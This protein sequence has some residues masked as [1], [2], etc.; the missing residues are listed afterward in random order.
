MKV[1]FTIKIQKESN[2]CHSG[3]DHNRQE[4]K[5]H[6][7]SRVQQKTCSFFFFD[8]K[9]TV[10]HEFLPPNTTVNSDF[11]CDLLRCW[12]KMSAEKDWKFGA[13]TTGSITTMCP[14]KRPWKPQSLLTNNNMVIV[15]HPPY[16]LDLAPVIWLCSPKWIRNWSDDIL[17]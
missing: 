13:T 12:R 7:R 10:H 6:G 1:T 2:N 14:P 11:F 3:R 5:R 16:S 4:Q 8:V 17:K 15:P 9:E